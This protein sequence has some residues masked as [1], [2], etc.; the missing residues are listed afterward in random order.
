MP[1]AHIVLWEYLPTRRSCNLGSFSTLQEGGVLCYHLVP[2]S[3][4]ILQLLLLCNSLLFS[5]F[6]SFGLSLSPGF[7]SCMLYTTGLHCLLQM[8]EELFLLLMPSLHFMTL[9]LKHF[10]VVLRNIRVGGKRHNDIGTRAKNFFF[11]LYIVDLGTIT[12]FL[13]K[14]NRTSKAQS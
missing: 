13:N 5:L 7:L 10:N 6:L 2:E 1:V 14:L 9:L 4:N 8:K 12:E 3:L 11:R